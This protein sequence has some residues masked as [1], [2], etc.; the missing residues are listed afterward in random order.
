MFVR[1]D[2]KKGAR[3]NLKHN[4][5]RAIIVAFIAFIL[6]NEG[7]N[8]VSFNINLEG[9]VTNYINNF[10]II[11]SVLSG[12]ESYV[13]ASGASKGILAIFA[14]NIASANSFF[15]GVLNGLNQIFF[16]NQIA[17]AI[18][19]FT[20]I[21]VG[22]F[23]WLFISSTIEVGRNRFF[24]EKVNYKNTPIDKILFVI[25]VKKTLNVVKIMFF[26]QLYT[27]LWCLTIVGGIVKYYSYLMIPYILAENPGISKKEAF[28][29]SKEMMD[30]QK[31][32]C[33]KL[34][35]SFLGWKILGLFTLNI[36]NLLITKPYYQMTYGNLYLNLRKYAL[37]HNPSLDHLFNDKRLTETGDIYPETVAKRNIRKWLKIDY[38]REYSVLSLVL[39][40][41]TIA[42]MGW[43]WEVALNLFR[44]GDFVNKGT[45]TGPWLPIYGAGGTIILVL[46]YKIKEKPLFVFILSLAIGGF[47]E[48]TVSCYLELVYHLKWWDYSGFFMNID[49]RI[50]LEVLILFGLG[51]CAVIYLIAP[52]LDNLYSKIPYLT[53]IVICTILITLFAMDFITSTIMPNM[54]DGITT[55]AMIMFNL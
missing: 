4:Y 38:D 40:F 5:W 21:I 7:Y 35:L 45:L 37:A 27:L 19:I 28:K 13:D 29:L 17:S 32:N 33:F 41:F 24:I 44:T 20:G 42:I 53:K 18:I 48:Y 31:W 26:R 12:F 52:L 11:D 23:F 30:G 39:I 54:G 15:V 2:L 9:T 47:I 1:K 36:S 6:I 51:G 25:R 16:H 3:K 55:V 14:N 22:F 8:L 10:H 46:L 50:C 34:D 43:F 49:G